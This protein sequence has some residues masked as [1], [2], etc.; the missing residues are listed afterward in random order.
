MAPVSW[1]LESHS[2]ARLARLPSSAG[3]A[4]VSW[5]L[6]SHSTREV[7]EVAEFCQE[8]DPVSWLEVEI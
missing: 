3:M 2:T 8:W 6:E 4:P 7:G 5:L 1:L